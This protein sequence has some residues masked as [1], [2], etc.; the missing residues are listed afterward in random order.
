MH[1][2]SGRSM[3]RAPLRGVQFPVLSADRKARARSGP[4]SSF[5]VR[6]GMASGGL[7]VNGAYRARTGDLLL[8]KQPLSQLS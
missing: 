3:E 7:G 1:Q 2:R 4:G 8:A 6:P 5:E